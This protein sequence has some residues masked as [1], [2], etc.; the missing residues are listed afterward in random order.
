METMV[1]FT[2]VFSGIVLWMV[3][4]MWRDSVFTKQQLTELK[5]MMVGL[6]L[7][8]T[9]YETYFE[10]IGNGL[11]Q[12]VVAINTSFTAPN[13]FQS[14][15]KTMDGKYSASS[16]EDLLSKI[17]RDGLEKKYLSDEELDSLRRMFQED[18]EQDDDYGSDNILPFEK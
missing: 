5:T 4:G 15:Y 14:M 1:I 8:L 9:T 18:D 10:K 12:L 13:S 16:L 7:R 17:R 11:N 3:A 6:N 2:L